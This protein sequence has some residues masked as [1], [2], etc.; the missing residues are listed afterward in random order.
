[1]T[2]AP[3][4]KA[5]SNPS[6]QTPLKIRRILAPTDLSDGSRKALNY[7]TRFAQHFGAK[8]TLIH[9]YEEPFIY[10]SAMSPETAQELRKARQGAENALLAIC[11]EIRA[12]YPK[13][14]SYFQCGQ[15]HELIV[16]AARILKSDLI[17]ISTHEYRW[18]NHLLF[19]SDAEDILHHAP[20]PVLVVHEK[21]R[22]LVVS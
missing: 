3:E 4:L 15:P 18:L 22:D 20:F 10:G 14:D 7:A 1:M 19:G 13:C 5:E 6:V 12:E 9:I 17:V 2:N 8:L 11:E 21:E 16:A